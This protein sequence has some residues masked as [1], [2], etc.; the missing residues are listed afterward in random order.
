M[1]IGGIEK[2]TLIDYPGKLAA[3]I[4]TQGCNFRCH[5][6]YNPM[7]V[8]PHASHLKYASVPVVATGAEAQDL[9]HEIKLSDL[10]SFLK[11]RQGILE[12]VVISGGEP[13][14]HPDLP[15]F[16]K[17]IRALGYAVKLDSNGT[18]PEMLEKVIKEG[19]VDYI[20]MDIKSSPEK[21][22]KTVGV[23]VH[24]VKS[25]EAGAAKPQ[26][27][28]VNIENIKKSI[29]IL[30]ESGLPHEFRTTLVPGLHEAVDVL[31]MGEMIKG[32]G[33]WFLQKFKSDTGL[34]NKAFEGGLAF[35][36]KE[37]AEMCE[38]GGRYV[39]LCDLR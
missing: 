4:F 24:H 23:A 17:D 21:Y 7:L 20:A 1:I 3:I 36:D 18:N 33:K 22:E 14:L 6:C 37:M 31:R 32:C 29:K 13:T 30:K 38:L 26:F 2:L 28:G 12:G 16:I 9:D 5:F 25:S 35:T 8:W 10:F 11:K 15:E 39:D 19:L 34:V 27:H